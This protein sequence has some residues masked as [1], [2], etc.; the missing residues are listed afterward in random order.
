MG[1]GDKNISETHRRDVTVAVGN[2]IWETL[3]QNTLTILRNL[4]PKYIHVHQK[5]VHSNN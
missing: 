2:K 4:S 3:F 5:Y 1:S